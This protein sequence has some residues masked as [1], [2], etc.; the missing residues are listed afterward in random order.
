MAD[1][2]TLR[3]EIDSIDDLLL[4]QLGRRFEVVR[5]VAAYKREHGIPAILPERIEAVKSRC[6][7]LAAKHDLD[8]AFVRALYDLIIKAACRLEDKIIQ[9]DAA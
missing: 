9:D 8:D 4:A 5:R 6:A 2:E 3:R 7:G 1:L